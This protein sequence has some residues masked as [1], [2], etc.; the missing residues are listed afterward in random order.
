[1]SSIQ[2]LEKKTDKK[3]LRRRPSPLLRWQGG[4]E[5]WGFQ[6]T[7]TMTLAQKAIYGGWKISYMRTDSINLSERSYRRNDSVQSP[8]VMVKISCKSENI[9]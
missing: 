8:A 1:V 4:Y 2:K 5:K 6:L 3:S 9:K 7:Q